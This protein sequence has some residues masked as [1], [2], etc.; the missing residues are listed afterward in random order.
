MKH[1]LQLRKI[2]KSIKT[3]LGQMEFNQNSQ[4]EEHF[5]N[6]PEQRNVVCHLPRYDAVKSDSLTI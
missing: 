6:S 4:K 5:Q 1:L 2:I 3:E